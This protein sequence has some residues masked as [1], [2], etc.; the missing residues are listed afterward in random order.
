[1]DDNRPEIKDTENLPETELNEDGVPRPAPDP[2][3][4]LYTVISLLLFAALYIGGKLI[5]ENFFL[6]YTVTLT[7]FSE[8]SAQILDSEA[9]EIIPETAELSY[10]RLSYGT[11]DNRLYLRYDLSAREEYENYLL[12]ESFI[13]EN[14]NGEESAEE[15]IS[16]FRN[17]YSD[18][19]YVYGNIYA[20]AKY[21]DIILRVYEYDGRDCAEIIKTKY[22]SSVRSA[23]KD[24][25][26]IKYENDGV[27]RKN[28]SE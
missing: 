8:R 27:F 1:M 13:T 12:S 18:L 28:R 11:D 17:E 25:I 20:S 3:N 16:V 19:D 14:P 2:K 9:S 10:A 23:F 26:K 24:G 21:P 6:P 22:D 4:G 5:S 15:R 7:E